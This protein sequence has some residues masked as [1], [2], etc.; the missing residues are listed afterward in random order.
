MIT[1]TSGRKACCRRLEA[2]SLHGPRPRLWMATFQRICAQSPGWNERRASLVAHA[3]C[4]ALPCRTPRWSGAADLARPIFE[5]RCADPSEHQ[6]VAHSPGGIEASVEDPEVAQHAPPLLDRRHGWRICFGLRSWQ[7][8]GG[9]TEGLP[10][11]T[12]KAAAVQIACRLRWHPRL[13]GRSPQPHC[14][15]LEARRTR[16]GA[17]RGQPPAG[18]DGVLS[19]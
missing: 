11:L 12:Q 13:F 1:T 15:G 17:L 14:S 8:L 5:R 16:R 7:Q 2:T 18:S 19:R 3:A 9:G 6:G 10:T 4:R